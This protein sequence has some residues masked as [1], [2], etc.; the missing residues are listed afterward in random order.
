M[1]AAAASDHGPTWWCIRVAGPW[2][3]PCM[4][5]HSR[6]FH[7]HMLPPFQ[8]FSGLENVS[9]MS[10]V[11]ELD[12]PPPADF[13]ALGSGLQAGKAH[14]KGSQPGTKA[15]TRLLALDGVQVSGA[16]GECMHACSHRMCRAECSGQLY[17][18]EHEPSTSTPTHNAGPRKP[19]HA[20]SFSAGLWMG[21]R[22]AA[23][24]LL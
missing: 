6:T 13:A 20:A 3:R 4:Q 10:A 21:W 22:V 12:I 19:G 16:L 7:A 24:R 23:A 5:Q 8:H 2:Q 1:Q 9:S 11:A 17:H 15:L 18:A 14:G